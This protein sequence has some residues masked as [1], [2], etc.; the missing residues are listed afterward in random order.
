MPDQSVAIA[1]ERRCCCSPRAARPK[2]LRSGRSRSRRH[3]RRRR[4]HRCA[5]P[6]CHRW[7]RVAL[8]AAAS[9]TWPCPPRWSWHLHR[10]SDH[11]HAT[12]PRDDRSGIDDRAVGTAP[13]PSAPPAMN[14]SPSIARVEATKL[15]PVSTCLAWADDHAMRF[16]DRPSASSML[17]I[18]DS[19]PPFTR[20]SVMPPPLR[21]DTDDRRRSR[22]HASRSPRDPS[23]G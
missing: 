6:T 21:I 11:H 20:L 1:G 4:R 7:R 13:S 16:I 15:P 19:V 5:S 18:R 9:V 12:G 8:S 14:V 2:P 17:S 3:A 23:A 22:N 10:A